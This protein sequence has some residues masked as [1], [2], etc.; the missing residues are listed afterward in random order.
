LQYTYLQHI[1]RLYNIKMPFDCS[2]RDIRRYKNV[3][4]NSIRSQCFASLLYVTGLLPTVNR[5]HLLYHQHKLSLLLS[6]S[7]NGDS[8]QDVNHNRHR[9]H[10]GNDFCLLSGLSTEDRIN[11]HDWASKFILQPKS[12]M[13]G[14]YFIYFHS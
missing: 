9:A 14:S 10:R 3:P 4:E 6:N 13:Y 8:H 2:D 11:L 5:Q 12:S 7:I 1:E